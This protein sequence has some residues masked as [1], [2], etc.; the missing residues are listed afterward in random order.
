MKQIQERGG[1]VNKLLVLLLVLAHQFD[2]SGKP[3]PA[4]KPAEPVLPG[5]YSLPNP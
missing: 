4:D 3:E 2:V 5:P 1:C